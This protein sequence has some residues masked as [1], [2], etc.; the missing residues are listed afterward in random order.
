MTPFSKVPKSCFFVCPVYSQDRGINVLKFKPK[1]YQETKQNGAKTYTYS[2]YS[3]EP[4]RNYWD[5]RGKGS[6]EEQI[7]SKDILSVHMEAIVFH[8]DTPQS[9]GRVY[10]NYLRAKIC[11]SL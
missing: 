1:I 3:F 4:V 10:T 2:K 7:M 6:I 11:D 8:S 5:F 9:Q